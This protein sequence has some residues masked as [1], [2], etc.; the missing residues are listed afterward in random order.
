MAG[1]LPASGFQQVAHR[2][3]LGQIQLAVQKGSP[4]KLPR[5]RLTGSLRK[6]GLQP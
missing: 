5:P 1:P 3:R 2:F 4:G 6:Q